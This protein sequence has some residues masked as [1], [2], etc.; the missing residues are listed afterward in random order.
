MHLK[1]AVLLC[2][3]LVLKSPITRATY[4]QYSKIFRQFLDTS[5]KKVNPGWC[6]FV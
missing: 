3:E 1:L 5:L 2:D 6:F 4:G